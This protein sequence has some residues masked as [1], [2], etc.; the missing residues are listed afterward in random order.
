MFSPTGEYDIILV[1]PTFKATI[2]IECKNQPFEKNRLTK[3]FNPKDPPAA[4][5]GVKEYVPQT[6]FLSTLNRGHNF[7]ENH[8]VV[9]DSDWVTIWM[10]CFSD[11]KTLQC[12]NMCDTCE[13][14]MTKPGR[15]HAKLPEVLVELGNAEKR[16]LL[17]QKVIPQLK[18]RRPQ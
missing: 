10:V 16:S 6:G 12:S 3:C 14:H 18:N 11:D 2:Q 4:T 13:A 7:L 17:A 15:L 1:L 8:L 5:F 9:D